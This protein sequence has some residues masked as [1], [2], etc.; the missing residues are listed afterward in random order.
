[1]KIETQ[2]EGNVLIVRPIHPQFQDWTDPSLTHVLSSLALAQGMQ[3]LMNLGAVDSL[4]S[5]GLGLLL[6]LKSRVGKSGK[7]VLCQVNPQIRALLALTQVELII[8]IFASENEA[9]AALADE[10]SPSLSTQ[11]IQFTIMSS[12]PNVQL[13]G[14]AINSIC[15]SLA[16]SPIDAYQ[17][18]LCAV[19]ALTNVVKHA[20]D[21]QSGGSVQLTFTIRPGQLTLKVCDE[22]RSM[23]PLVAPVLEFDPTEVES[24]PESGMG[25]FLIHS[26]MDEV[27]Y[28]SE[29][30]TNSLTMIK[31][32]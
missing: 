29:H 14:V 31:K 24:L 15:T 30:G 17:I 5:T 25:L 11:E 27:S 12:L 1:M 19:E 18:Q 26:F 23:P 10:S 6:S 32:F 4:D 2:H 21:G 13:V 16:F 9:L 8:Q 3:V 22:G 7:L 20:Y 28:A